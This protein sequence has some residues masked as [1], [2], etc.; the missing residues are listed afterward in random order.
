MINKSVVFKMIASSSKQYK[1]LNAIILSI[2]I[3][4]VNH[5]FRIQ[6]SANVFLHNNPM[7]SHIA[8][9]ASK[10]ML[11]GVDIKISLRLF[12]SS[13]PHR[14]IFSRQCRAF[15]S[16]IPR[17]HNTLS[18]LVPRV[19]FLGHQ[20]TSFCR[21]PLAEHSSGFPN[22]GYSKTFSCAIESTPKVNEGF[23]EKKTLATCFTNLKRNFPAHSR[24][25]AFV[26]TILCAFRST[27]E[28]IKDLRADLAYF[29]NHVIMIA[30]ILRK[31]ILKE[32]GIDLEA[33][34]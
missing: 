4:M 17:L 31:A 8:S 11:W 1:V 27:R 15:F 21:V 2:P 33:C 24:M 10:W 16:F 28:Y 22:S 5:F 12:S 7:L 23:S 13:A 19:A 26:R 9:L 3:N 14:M 32:Q 6:K 20:E 30:G 25:L 18:T 29:F 34:S